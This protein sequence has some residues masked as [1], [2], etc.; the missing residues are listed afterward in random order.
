[1]DGRYKLGARC[2][3][4]P[5]YLAGA[6]SREADYVSSAN[7]ARLGYDL[8]T[9]VLGTPEGAQGGR[10]SPSNRRWA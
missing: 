3:S 2:L 1:M 9:T 8:G 6:L 5:I 4:A 7:G 10:P